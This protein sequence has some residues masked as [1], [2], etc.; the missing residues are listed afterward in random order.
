SQKRID[1]L[2]GTVTMKCSLLTTAVLAVGCILAGG[3][4]S[5]AQYPA[6][7]QPAVSPYLNLFRP[8]GT[9]G[10]NYYNF[11]QPQLSFAGGINSLQQQTLANQQLITGLQVG[12]P[13]I[14]GQPF[15]FN[16]HLGYFQNQLRGG[17]GGG[18]M[19]GGG[20]GGQ[21]GGVGTGG[22]ATFG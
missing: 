7:S 21:A 3:E 5:P 12:N 20:M 6:Y 18:G 16:T 4:R 10:A 8:G 13:R 14:T 2:R 11:V 1:D 15:G 19:G 17:L 9:P 22:Q